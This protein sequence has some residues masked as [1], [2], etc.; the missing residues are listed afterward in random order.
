MKNVFLTE[1]IHKNGVELLEKVAVVKLGTSLDK[2]VIIKEAQGC[3]AILIRSA[4]ITEE[5]MK[6]IPTLKVIGKHGIGVDNIDV[7][8]ATKLGIL[9]VNAPESNV[10]AVAEHVFGMIFALSKNFVQMDQRTRNG[11]FSMR[12]KVVNTELKGK[13]VGIIGLGKIAMLLVRK[14]SA[15]DVNIIGYDPFV[16]ESIA[17]EQGINLV[18]NINDLYKQADFIT[19]NVP[20]TKDTKDMIGKDQFARMKKNACFINAARGEIVKE[21]DLYEALKN[22]VIK[23]AAIDV[24]DK[25]PPEND[26]LLFTLDNI[27][28]SPHNAAL[29]DEALINM[30]VHSAKG[31]V[32]FLESK[33]PK[34]IVNPKCI[35]NDNI[36]GE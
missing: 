35:Y 12:T 32:D 8:A 7:E 26:N 5:I 29:A 30:A 6:S 18:C 31:I 9:V 21:M 34:Y 13:T 10:N 27:L 36:K 22:G 23:A 2:D 28:L 11:Q 17:R 1:P 4:K 16:N 25:E 20:L 24:F 15:L 3:D 33:T 19:V 14:L